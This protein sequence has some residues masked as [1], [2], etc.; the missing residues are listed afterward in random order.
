MRHSPSVA[1]ALALVALANAPSAAQSAYVGA[2]L[3]GDV[4]R[5]G[6]TESGGAR[7]S[8]GGGEAFGFALRLGT[9][10]GSRWGVDLEFVRPGEV[11]TDFTPGPIPLAQQSWTSSVES[12]LPR[13][14]TSVQLFPQPVYRV[15]TSQ[16][17]TTL[18]TSAWARQELSQRVSLVYLAGMGFYRETNTSEIDINFPNLP[19]GLIG[20]PIVFPPTTSQTV[21]YGVRPLAGVEAR[22]GLTD[23]VELVPGL[24][25]HGLASGWLLRPAVGL[26]WNF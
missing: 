18:S 7:Q 13:V 26:Q 8:F 22:I 12:L 4:V 1:I 3:V 11:D 9:P 5:V 6:H 20:P 15:R 16:R 21:T 2:S 24:R 23:H 19:P 14:T 10:L 17:Y 25:L